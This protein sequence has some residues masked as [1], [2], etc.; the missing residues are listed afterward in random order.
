MVLL[1]LRTQRWSII[2][3]LYKRNGN[4]NIKDIWNVLC[5]EWHGTIMQKI[6]NVQEHTVLWACKRDWRC[7]CKSWRIET[8]SSSVSSIVLLLSFTLS[9][10]WFN[11]SVDIN[12]L[13]LWSADTCIISMRIFSHQ[14]TRIDILNFHEKYFPINILKRK[15]NPNWSQKVV[16]SRGEG[17]RVTINLRDIFLEPKMKNH[18]R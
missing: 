1:T 9:L 7:W 15:Q 17:F 12:N 6:D 4:Q 8:P 14:Q 18:Y 5:Y 16:I 2:Y 10:D 11:L 13:P 3:N